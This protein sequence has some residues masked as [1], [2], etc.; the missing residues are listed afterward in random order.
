LKPVGQKIGCPSDDNHFPTWFENAE[1][2]FRRAGV[3]T[4]EDRFKL[5]RDAL[6]DEQA[7]AWEKFVSAKTHSPCTHMQHALIKR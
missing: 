3:S 7:N 1:S 2:R 4:E 5:F 6:F